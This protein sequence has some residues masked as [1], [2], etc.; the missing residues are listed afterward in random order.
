[1]PDCE[2]SMSQGGL[3][4][5]DA[6]LRVE[7]VAGAAAGGSDA[8]EGADGVVTALVVHAAVDVQL[9]LVQV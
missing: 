1:M 6:Q 8:G 4:F 3:T 7:R 5:A 9:A 2:L